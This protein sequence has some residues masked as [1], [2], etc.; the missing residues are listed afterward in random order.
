MTHF[1]TA[2]ALGVSGAA[3]LIGVLIVNDGSSMRRRR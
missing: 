2:V 3:F 1:Q